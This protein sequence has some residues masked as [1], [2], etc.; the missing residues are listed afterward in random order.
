[1]KVLHIIDTLASGGAQ[2]LIKNLFEYQN[3]NENIFLFVLRKTKIINK[4]NHQNIFIFNSKS[5]FSLKPLFEIKNQINK[6]Q[7]QIIHC[8]LFRS[9]VFGYLIKLLFFPKIKLIFHEHGQILGSETKSRIEDKIFKLFLKISKSK[10]DKF[11]PVSNISAEMLVSKAKVNSS[12]IYRL[13]NFIDLERIKNININ[14]DKIRNNFENKFVVGFAGRIVE[15][16]GWRELIKSIEILKND[17]ILLLIAGD[18]IDSEKLIRE[19]VDKNLSENVKYLGY[20]FDINSDFF[21]LID[22]LIVPSHKE[23]LG[24]VALEAFA[25]K[26][27]VIASNIPGLTEIVQHN[28]NGLLF[29]VKN[30]NDLAEKIKYISENHLI[31]QRLIIQAY[32]D[33]QEFDIKK[34]IQNLNEIYIK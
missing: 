14:R 27:V 33:I 5:R 10:V 26:K 23:A 29:N 24:I 22:C 3:D 18:G 32:I 30:E 12:K 25:H 19:I 31:K 20:L 15:T 2:I 16:K 7:I 17:K 28:K 6:N 9:Q 4:I 11:I 1:M 21:S 13:Y 34:Y 8:H